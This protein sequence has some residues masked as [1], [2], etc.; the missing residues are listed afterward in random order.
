MFKKPSEV[1]GQQRLSGADKKKLRRAIKEIFSSASEEAIDSILPAKAD[2]T[3]TKLVNRA[4]VYAVEGEPPMLFDVD[5]RGH[6][7]LPTVYALWKVPY[8]VPS[9]ELKGGE[10]SRYVLGGADLM[11]PGIAV[12]PEG[13][14]NFGVDEVWAV[15]VP[16]N[17]SPIA[18]G[19][20]ATSSEQAQRAG[21]RGKALR[22][23]H[24]YQ[25]TLWESADGKY[26]PNAGFLDG[27]V[28][29]DPAFTN[30]SNA[31]E[32]GT[33]NSLVNEAAGGQTELS[34][35]QPLKEGYTGE[36]KGRE[37][38]IETGEA[39]HHRES[40]DGREEAR[41]SG[42]DLAEDFGELQV[43][44]GEDNRGNDNSAGNP[45]LTAEDMDALLN[46]CLLQALRTSV[47]DK[48]LPIPGST[49]WS[50]HILP[51]RP[52]GSTL[53]VKKSSHKKL[54]KWLQVAASSGLVTAKEDKHRK[55]M[56]L[57]GVNRRHPEYLSFVPEKIIPPAETT[58]VAAASTDNQDET[59]IE[60]VEV[61]KVTHQVSPIFDAV[62]A[63]AGSYYSATEA[64]E[65]AFRYVEIQSLEKRE[66]RAL[67]VLDVTLC[68][69]LFKGAIKKGTRYPEEIH[70]KDIGSA[71]VKRMQAHH[72]VTRGSQSVV[73]KGT[74]QSVQIVTERRQGNKKVT[75][76]TGVESF[77]VDPETLGAELQ[78][79]FA[80]STSV[81]EVAG[82]K[83]QL[84]V[85]VQGGV[86]EDLGRH[87]V[88]HYGIPKKHIEIMDK[89]KKS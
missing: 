1:R 22:I 55:E 14:P 19:S 15:R 80:C 85:L 87:L 63:D 5:G 33:G 9:L 65:V 47:K 60:V 82:K 8:L 40:Q 89:T 84:E 13:L 54:S 41:A 61:Y 30:V 37:A 67:V 32:V 77:L 59:A 7:I 88:Q 20:T 38:V 75:R 86:L 31:D 16:R 48:E 25:D 73:R 18:V 53:D 44:G 69:A 42:G 56:I 79:K 76:L 36:G 52:P 57:T 21:L 2:I 10:V 62:G 66:N 11:L 27:M 4:L 68:D 81:A 46:K 12:P 45:A 3:V 72:R 43:N 83:G 17:A 58:P 64:S 6:N 78:K 71:F 35:S 26:I 29:E 24:Y 70:K 51:N 50:N 49:L 74:L 23:M 39:Q 28:V 34:E